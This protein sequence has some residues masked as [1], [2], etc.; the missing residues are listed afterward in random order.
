MEQ[1]SRVDNIWESATSY[2]TFSV[3]A[4]NGTVDIVYTP[5]EGGL[6]YL[7]AFEI[8]TPAIENQ[9]SFP[10]PAH[11]DE[12][13]EPEGGNSV[14]ASWLPPME[15]KDISYDVYFGTSPDELKVV[16]EGVNSTTATLSGKTDHLIRSIHLVC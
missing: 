7:N 3:G 15:A 4:G 2:V 1:S 12:R 13:L 10:A 5:S 8:D 16:S 9:I 14:V 11:R 6:A